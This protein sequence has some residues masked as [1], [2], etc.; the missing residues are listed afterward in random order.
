MEL[1]M[2]STFKLRVNHRLEFMP[3]V[4]DKGIHLHVWTHDEDDGEE[5][6]LTWEDLAK[7]EIDAQ[8]IPNTDIVPFDDKDDI[9]KTFNIVNELRDA[10]DYLEQELMSL[11]ALDRKAWIAAQIEDLN[12]DKQDF[13]KPIYDVLMEK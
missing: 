8:V 12:A 3:F 1:I 13:I 7:E 11:Q 4:S 5:M 10:A 2:S 6:L 9:K